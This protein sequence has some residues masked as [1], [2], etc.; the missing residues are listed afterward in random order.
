MAYGR[1]VT[2]AQKQITSTTTYTVNIYEN[3]KGTSSPMP[4]V[5]AGSPFVTVEW[6]QIGGDPHQS[7]V[8]SRATVVLYDKYDWLFRTLAGANDKQFRIEILAG[9]GDYWD[10]FMMPDAG[11]RST[12]TF[13]N[14]IIILRATDGMGYL[15]HI[16]YLQADG[17]AYTGREK[18]QTIIQRCLALAGLKDHDLVTLV[19]W[20]PYLANQL[21]PDDDIVERVKVNQDWLYTDQGDVYSAATI[22]KQLAGR[23][24]S[25][26]FLYGT[27]WHFQQRHETLSS[28]WGNA[29]LYDPAGVPDTPVISIT[30]PGERAG[31]GTESKLPPIGEVKTTYRHGK[32]YSLVDNAGFDTWELSSAMPD[33]WQVNS[34]VSS[35][36]IAREVS[37]TG[38]GYAIYIK[39]VNY[40]AYSGT[41]P[42]HYADG[43]VDNIA[44]G[45]VEGGSSRYII[46][47]SQCMIMPNPSEL[48]FSN[49]FGIRIMYRVENA[50]GDFWCAKEDGTWSKNVDYIMDVSGADLAPGQTTGDHLVMELLDSGAAEVT[51]VVYIRLYRLEDDK[52]TTTAAPMLGVKFDNVQPLYQDNDQD[53]A[54]PLDTSVTL[55]VDDTDNT[56]YGDTLT[57]I[58]GDGPTIAHNGRFTVLDSTDTE[59]DTAITAGWRDA[60]YESISFSTSAVSAGADTITI[61]TSSANPFED[62]DPIIVTSTNTA[63]A[64]ITAGTT[65]Y[66]VNT[67]AS[68]VQV[69][70]SATGPAIDITDVGVGTHTIA[71]ASTGKSIDRLHAENRILERITAIKRRYER[72]KDT[73]FHPYNTWTDNLATTV[74]STA[75]GAVT[76]IELDDPVD[77]GTVITVDL[78]PSGTGTA[79]VSG[80]LSNDDGTYDV[81]FTPALTD[82]LAGGDVVWSEVYSWTYLKVMPVERRSEGEFVQYK[83][84]TDYGAITAS[85]SY[86]RVIGA[87]DKPTNTGQNQGGN[88]ED[89]EADEKD[90]LGGIIRI[91]PID[92]P[93]SISYSADGLKTVEKVAD[94]DA[95]VPATRVSYAARKVSTGNA[96]SGGVWVYDPA[97]TATHNGGTVRRPTT[98]SSGDPGRW[99]RETQD[100]RIHNVLDYDIDSSGALDVSTT[101]QTIITN[102]ADGDHLHFPAGTYKVDSTINISEKALSIT[103]DFPGT[104]FVADGEYEVFRKY[105]NNDVAGNSADADS[106]VLRRDTPLFI[107]GLTFTL[108]GGAIG[109]MLYHP[110]VTSEINYS[111]A[112]IENCEFILDGYSTV[113]RPSMGICNVRCHGVRIVNC[114]FYSKVGS[115]LVVIPDNGNPHKTLVRWKDNSAAWEAITSDTFNVIYLGDDAL[116]LTA[117]TFETN[118]GIVITADPG[119]SL[120]PEIPQEQILFAIDHT[121]DR[122]RITEQIDGT[123]INITGAESGTAHVI[124]GYRVFVY[125]VEIATGKLDTDFLQG[126]GIYQAYSLN[127]SVDNCNFSQLLG[128]VISDGGWGNAATDGNTSTG[129]GSA[130]EAGLRVSNCFGVGC[131]E[132]VKVIYH[133][134]PIVDGG[135]WDYCD[136]PLQFVGCFGVMGNGWTGLRSS[137][138]ARAYAVGVRPYENLNAEISTAETGFT[139]DLSLHNM[140][141]YVY[142]GFVA[143]TLTSSVAAGSVSKLYCSGGSA[144]ALYDK[145]AVH[146]EELDGSSYPQIQEFIVNGDHAA[147]VTSIAVTAVTTNHTFS[148]SLVVRYGQAKRSGVLLDRVQYADLSTVNI[149]FWNYAAVLMRDCVVTTFND[150]VTNASP[151]GY[152]GFMLDF[153]DYDAGLGRYT[154]PYI[155]E[156][157]ASFPDAASVDNYQAGYTWNRILNPFGAGARIGLPTSYNANMDVPT[158]WV[159]S[160]A[161]TS[162][163]HVVWNGSPAYTTLYLCSSNHTSG[164]ST[165][166]GVGASWSTVWTAVT[167]TGQQGS[168]IN[169]IT[170][171]LAAKMD[172]SGVQTIADGGLI[173]EDPVGE[174]Y[175]MGIY[176]EDTGVGGVFAG[177]WS[178]QWKIYTDTWS[179]LMIGALGA[180]EAY[181][182]SYISGHTTGVTGEQESVMWLKFDNSAGAK[183]VYLPMASLTLASG[184]VSLVSSGAVVNIDGNQVL[185]S[186]LA[187]ISKLTNSTGGSADATLSA[188]SGTG[189]DANINNNF[190]EVNT[191][192]DLLIDALGISSGH[193]LTGD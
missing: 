159:T 42:D 2:S 12:D 99:L 134:Y 124:K 100:F 172:K 111:E 69:S 171:S 101:V 139:F 93:L 53:D 187:A 161:Y 29:F 49:A 66:I 20:F 179:H 77:I 169:N 103:G 102:A 54:E 182:Y 25:R 60:L 145:Q 35:A 140:V 85:T 132:G 22:L 61:F 167:F 110:T 11:S 126:F 1:I 95:Y 153:G 26:I 59:I 148:N 4:S 76:T 193:G 9:A 108:S 79:T 96:R 180:G 125:D 83:R 177:T 74:T 38:N 129:R 165:E 71:D 107:K 164:A 106:M 75:A 114:N 150:Q 72:F 156:Y 21:T 43:Y 91:D 44:G 115:S 17:S 30:A 16:P 86:R 160:T 166:P 45:T 51:G 109:I 158:K 152:Y 147:S 32:L 173:A 8:P 34:G 141:T 82:V 58:I 117:H 78:D 157:S 144:F 87:Y 142:N 97:S 68:T 155:N 5:E 168:Y 130:F 175:G 52:T 98:V 127:T 136:H 80:L 120:P 3:G 10:G 143:A 119:G 15:N 189:D 88:I 121:A 118:D 40:S 163:T 133:D 6:G 138:S 64:G 176:I 70:A 183:R 137:Q 36:Q 13:G 94:L 28:G 23:F 151:C 31:G 174:P 192:L 56:T 37:F 184:S 27:A 105:D 7:M 170:T 149:G 41:H 113:K 73:V 188:V 104:K 123:K 63:P 50:G 39:G 181:D 191:K 24:L 190:T 46:W 162:G 14:K 116:A 18:A 84:S 112:E 55:T 154:T 47:K 135:M 33:N 19:R 65:Y 62:E 81:T 178:R 67:A 128:G 89:E 92:K 186:R 48:D 57:Y 90:E 131:Y 146:L 185:K 122:V